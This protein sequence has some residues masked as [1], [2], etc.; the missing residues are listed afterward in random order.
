MSQRA[1]RAL[2][3]TTGVI[4]AIAVGGLTL[5]FLIRGLIAMH[6]G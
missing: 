3:I 1:R 5:H 2:L 6:G 4:A